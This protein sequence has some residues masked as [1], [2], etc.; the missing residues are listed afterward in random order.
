MRSMRAKAASAPRL[1]SSKP[2]QLRRHLR[3][4]LLRLLA[5]AAQLL[6]VLLQ[7]VDFDFRRLMLCFEARSFFALLFDQRLAD[8]AQI[9]VALA[10]H[11]PVIQAP[12][13]PR[14]FRIHLT[15]GGAL[16]GAFPLRVA[17]LF[18]DSFRLG[19]QLAQQ[20]GQRSSGHFRAAPARPR[21]GPAS[22]GFRATRPSTP[23]DPPPWAY[24]R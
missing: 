13:Q 5:L 9:L 1:R 16:V 23:A 19:R 21:P 4:L 18:A 3:C 11:H 7:L 12:L 17:P 10:L 22:S 24:R 8:V 6:H 2:G 15:Q 14:H 20:P